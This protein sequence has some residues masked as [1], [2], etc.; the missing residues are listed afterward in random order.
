MNEMF[1]NIQF[2]YS[3]LNSRCVIF[4]QITV[5]QQIIYLKIL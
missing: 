5:Q 1:I 4:A 2:Q 3:F